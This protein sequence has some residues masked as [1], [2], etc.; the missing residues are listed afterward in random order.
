MELH[1]EL[2]AETLFKIGPIPVTNSMLAMFLV[3]G[4][5]LLVGS[6]IARRAQTIPTSHVQ[7]DRRG[8]RR[9]PARPRRGLP[10][11][12]APGGASSR[13][14]AASSSSS[15]SPT[16]PVSSPASARS[17]TGTRRRAEAEVATETGAATEEEHPAETDETT[18]ERPAGGD[19]RGRRTRARPRPLPAGAQRRPEHDAGDGAADL[20]GR[21]GGRHQRPRRRRPDQAHG[22]SLVDLP[23]GSRSR[24]SPA[25]SR[26]RSGSSATS[27]PAR[28]CWR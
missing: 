1:V 6:T 7:V 12:S 28:C 27:S 26:S 10:P 13:W 15:S 24:S 17:A 9:V 21:P 23:A 16:T 11:A 8:D 20:H 18:P 14:S 2:A 4:F 3:M 5:L 19:R 25:S 22:R